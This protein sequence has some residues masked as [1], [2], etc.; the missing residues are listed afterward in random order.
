M[1]VLL[2]SEASQSSLTI[3]VLEA[4]LVLVLVSAL[5]WLVLRL[6]AARDR[7]VKKSGALVIEERVALDMKSALFV[8]RVDHARRFLVAAADGAPPRLL[9][10]LDMDGAPQPG[11]PT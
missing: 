11:S 6:V 8:V 1:G 3:M 9:A 10:E 5:A 4:L 2:S 7:M